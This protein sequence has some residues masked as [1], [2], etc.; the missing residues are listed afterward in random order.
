MP[1][2]QFTLEYSNGEKYKLSGRQIECMAEIDSFDG[3]G[4]LQAESRTIGALERKGL[5]AT[6]PAP[7]LTD[8]GA[9]VL[10]SIRREAP[11]LLKLLEVS[12]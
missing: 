3:D 12:E 11:F 4:D 7:R 6:S 1:T 5:I 8:K 10:E 2:N 9:R